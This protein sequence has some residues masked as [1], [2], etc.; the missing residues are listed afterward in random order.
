M[1]RNTEQERQ[2]KTAQTDPKHVDSW[3]IFEG[4][5]VSISW[6]EDNDDDEFYKR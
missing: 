5:T 2:I 6:C 3:R 4:V 1:E